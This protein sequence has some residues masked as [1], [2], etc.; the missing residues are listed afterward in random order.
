MPIFDVQLDSYVIIGADGWPCYGAT[1]D[2]CLQSYYSH[3]AGLRKN[4]DSDLWQARLA[5]ESEHAIAWQKQ[6]SDLRYQIW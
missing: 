4:G 6:Q 2:A 5:E 3:L 1:A